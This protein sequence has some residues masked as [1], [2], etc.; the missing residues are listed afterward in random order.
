MMAAGKMKQV[1]R[2]SGDGALERRAEAS[3]VGEEECEQERLGD[4]PAFYP[5]L[6]RV[7]H[8]IKEC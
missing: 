7:V 2:E 1:V 5:L 8:A 4:L 3:S 6:F